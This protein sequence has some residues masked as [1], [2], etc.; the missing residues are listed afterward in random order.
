MQ[1]SAF[2]HEAAR[3]SLFSLS[4]TPDQH[5]DMSMEITEGILP[6]EKPVMVN[7]YLKFA[8]AMMVCSKNGLGQPRSKAL[9]AVRLLKHSRKVTA[10]WR[11]VQQE[12]I[13]RF[14]IARDIGLLTLLPIATRGTDYTWLKQLVS[15]RQEKLTALSEKRTVDAKEGLSTTADDTWRD[16]YAPKQEK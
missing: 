9:K 16:V 6:A 2:P 1:R 4:L 5:Y 12:R 3:P 13:R 11:K 10:R 8:S 15:V 7:A 14:T